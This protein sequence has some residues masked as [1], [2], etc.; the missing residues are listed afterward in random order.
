MDMCGQLSV[1]H[2]PTLDAL[3]YD[4]PL[5]N[6]VL[7]RRSSEHSVD[8]ITDFERTALHEAGHVVA[9]IQLGVD[10]Q[11]YG[12][13]TIVPKDQT[14]GSFS[15]CEISES[16][17]EIKR[18]IVINCA[19]YGALRALGY[20]EDFACRGCGDDFVKS[21][22]LIDQYSLLPLSHWK[23]QAT[24]LLSLP[25][26]VLAVRAI[27]DNLL[28]YKILGP[29]YATVVFEFAIGMISSVEF[30]QFKVN[31]GDSYWLE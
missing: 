12:R 11:D 27:A 31:C 25:D 26:N 10:G 23:D 21:A 16:I 28:K 8:P 19:G 6:L 22:N 4:L 30:D 20:P 7:T 15:M 2:L 18:D 29:V 14:N 1:S 17:S 13:V 9:A 3:A 24:Q 5:E